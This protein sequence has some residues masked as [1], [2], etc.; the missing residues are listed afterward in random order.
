[1]KIMAYF[2]SPNTHDTLDSACKEF[3][4][5]YEASAGAPTLDDF[6]A[7]KGKGFDAVLVAVNPMST[8][9]FT[10]LKESGIKQVVSQSVGFDHFDKE[11]AKAAGIGINHSSYPPASVASYAVM[12]MLMCARRY[13]TL[14]TRFRERDFRVEECCRGRDMSE[15]TVGVIGTGKIG[16]A[17]CRRLRGF[18]CKILC[19][20]IYENEGLKEYCEYTDLD[21]LLKRC[22]IITLHAFASP[23]NYHLINAEKLA[24]MKP[25][26]YIVNT[27]RGSLIDA[28]ALAAAIKAGKL[29]GAALDV[30]EVENGFYYTDKRG[31]ELPAIITEL[32]S[33]PEVTLSSHMAFCTELTGKSQV[34]EAVKTAY[35]ALTGQPNP[36]A[37]L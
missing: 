31:Q 26:A 11:A 19:Y 2:D 25:T 12:L 30:L 14:Q 15:L 1:M 23:E 7:L 3:G 32:E 21:D 35:L 10:V 6:K 13:D 29:G 34:Y 18:D 8:E 16:Q 33:L 28:D 17:V 37:V 20:D 4:L 27:A 5:E 36:N 9:E 22:D 24:L